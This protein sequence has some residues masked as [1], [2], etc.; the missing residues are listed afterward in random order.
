MKFLIL[1]ILTIN[2]NILASDL[3]QSD[4]IEIIESLAKSERRSLWVQGHEN[5]VS[6]IE[7]VT[8][9]SLVEY[10]SQSKYYESNLEFDEE[11][12][13]FG[14]LKRKSCE[15]YLISLS[16]EYYSGYGVDSVFVQLNVN[17]GNYDNRIRHNIYSE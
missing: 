7:H 13:L 12:K 9:T 14:C 10:L 16:S 8:K 4:Q 2:T 1:L 6:S 15:L 5:V 17:T 3:T 11:D